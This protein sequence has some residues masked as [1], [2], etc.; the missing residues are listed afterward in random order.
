MPHAARQ[1]VIIS[2]GGRHGAS[3]RTHRKGYSVPQDDVDLIP[4]EMLGAVTDR[5]QPVKADKVPAAEKAAKARR[6]KKA[7][8]KAKKDAEKKAS[9][10]DAPAPAPEGEGASEA[11]W[12]P[13]TKRELTLAKKAKVDGLATRLGIHV[14]ENEKGRTSLLRDL[15]ATHLGL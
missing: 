7:K 2:H 3:S 14:D 6:A 4:D 10:K 15:I 1:N 9:K 12:M 8:A 5:T 13:E 11:P